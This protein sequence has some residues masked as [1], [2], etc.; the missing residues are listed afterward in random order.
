MRF[1]ASPLM[2]AVALGL[3]GPS[4]LEVEEEGLED[5]GLSDEDAAADLDADVDAAE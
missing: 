2:V 4:V 5:H 1:N 3:L